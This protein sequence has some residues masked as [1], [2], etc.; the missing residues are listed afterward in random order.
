MRIILMRHGKPDLTDTKPL[1]SHEFHQWIR[2]YNSAPL[3]AESTPRD[4]AKKIASECVLVVCSHLRRSQESAQRLGVAIAHSD[5]IFREME[6]PHGKL[7]L[8]KL[9][10]AVWAL[11]F[12]CLWFMGYA[13]NSETFRAAR[14]RAALAAQQLQALAQQHE[15]VLFIG[16]GL[17]NRFVAKELRRNG[18]RGSANPSRRYWD[19]GVYEFFETGEQA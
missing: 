9:L 11:F 15:S 3:C 12:R 19:F 8:P 4:D 10:P 17:L 5:E 1:A 2:A 16:H 14:G 7:Y 13:R 18:W 6:M